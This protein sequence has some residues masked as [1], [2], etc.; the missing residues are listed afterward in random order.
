MKKTL[1]VI[2]AAIVAVP[3]VCLPV[4]AHANHVNDG[5]TL[6]F[7]GATATNAFGDLLDWNGVVFG[8]ANNIIDLEGSLAVGGS[9]YSPRGLSVN[10]G[11]YGSQNLT[12]EDVAFLVN[13]NVNISGYGSV[14]GQTV[15]G[16]ADGNTYHLSNVTP[17][18]TTNGQFA[19]ADSSRYFAD[20]K[21]TAYAVKAAV[22]ALPVNGVCDAAYGTYTFVG[23][24]DAKTLVY[25]VDDANISSYIFDF[26]IAEGQTVVV[27]FTTSDTLRFKY[28]AVRINGKSDQ[29][30]LR[31]F[32]R[33]IILNVVSAD[34][35]EMTGCELYGT[36]LAPDAELIGNDANVCGTSILNGLTGNGGF[37]LHVGYNNS[38]IPAVSGSTPDPADPTDPA[39]PADPEDPTD[40][41]EVLPTAG[42]IRIDV[43][44]KMAVAFADGTVYYGG[45][46]KEVVFNQE[47]TF[48]M[49]SVNWDNGVYD[50][51]GNGLRGS[52][53]YRMIVVHK[54]E[55]NRRAQE[56]KQD[57][58]RYT[59]KG[60]D[61]ID[62]VGKI[63]IINGDAKDAHLETD[64]NNF[65]MAYR[66]HFTGQDYNKKTGIAG[67][68]NTPIESLSVNLPLGSTIACD[69]YVK[70]AKVDS[71]NVF[72][73]H[74]SGKGVY[75]DVELTSVNDYTW[76]H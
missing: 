55:F 27:N 51:N 46:M 48:Q 58:D 71:A 62:N 33:N 68:I 2:L 40:P 14:W 43:P 18:A 39:D 11:A 59:V 47:Y 10:G 52:V 53:V 70:G 54:D 60:I 49:C 30:Y 41:A 8:D 42:N 24:A 36:L 7:N 6:S 12:T 61:I 73:E 35:I 63:I 37:E 44:L 15:V 34:K 66:F 26:T 3:A 1:S 38:F 23:D 20:A 4:S 76:N 57:P 67:V 75:N 74:N 72:I 19:V 31:Q 13:G 25:N 17:S 5:D 29:Q 28:G 69:A 64:V 9:F 50:E 32:N 21:N 45:E 65:F 16:N 22:D 56:A